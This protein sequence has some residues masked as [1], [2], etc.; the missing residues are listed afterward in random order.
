M[1]LEFQLF[2]RAFKTPSLRSVAQRAPFMH[3]G[4]L[5]TLE[6]VIEHYN[7]AFPALLGQSEIAPLALSTRE[8]AAL[9][10]FLRTL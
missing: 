6:Q 10:A 8:K 1:A 9:L 2:D 4:Q 7:N 3:A 5:A